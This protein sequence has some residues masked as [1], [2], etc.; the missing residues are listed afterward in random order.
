MRLVSVDIGIR[1]LAVVNTEYDCGTN[2]FTHIGFH[3]YSKSKY[4]GVIDV[5]GSEGLR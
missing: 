4:S 5:I 1:N 3:M 2:T